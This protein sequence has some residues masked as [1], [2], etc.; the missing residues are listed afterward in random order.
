MGKK[1]GLI[2]LVVGTRR[3]SLSFSETTDLVSVVQ[4]SAGG[5][6][7]DVSLAYTSL[8]AVADLVVPA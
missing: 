2:D 4:A 6:V 8:S 7:V 5:V 1:R 3:A